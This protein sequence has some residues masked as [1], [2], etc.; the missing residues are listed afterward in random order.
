[1]THDAENPLDLQVG[2]VLIP[3][4]ESNPGATA[5]VLDYAM[6]LDEQ[7]ALVLCRWRG[8][9]VIWTMEDSRDRTSV[10][11]GSYFRGAAAREQAIAEAN[12][13]SRL[14]AGIE[15]LHSGIGEQP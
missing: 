3:H 14:W 5:T 12:R 4:P 8:E 11:S 15:V 6:L 13:L 10:H 7:R 2:S 1:M 9:Y